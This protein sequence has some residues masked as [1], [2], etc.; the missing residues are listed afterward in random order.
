[1]TVPTIRGTRSAPPAWAAA[2]SVIAEFEPE[3]SADLVNFIAAQARGVIAYAEALAEKYDALTSVTRLDPASVRG[4]E[5][6]AEIFTDAGAR[7]AGVQNE[8]R[9]TYAGV[10]EDVERGVQMPVKGDFLAAGTGS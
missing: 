5:H 7:L 1:M 8:F 9:K 3:D 4:L 2:A 6:A 10:L